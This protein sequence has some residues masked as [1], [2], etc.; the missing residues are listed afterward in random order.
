M[1]MLI[2][3]AI[4]GFGDAD[5]PSPSA[6]EEASITVAD[7]HYG[8]TFMP[9]SDFKALFEQLPGDRTGAAWCQR[10]CVCVCV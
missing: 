1:R 2:D 9:K 5:I 7:L 4:G 3:A 10:A 6:V 8:F